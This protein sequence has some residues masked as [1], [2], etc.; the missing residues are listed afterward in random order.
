MNRNE[1][2]QKLNEMLVGKSAYSMYKLSDYVQAHLGELGIDNAQGEWR[3]GLNAYTIQII[4]K[5]WVVV[6][7]EIKRAKHKEFVWV[8][9]Q[10]VVDDYFVD[11]ETR[12]S[13]IH[14]KYKDQIERFDEWN[15][16][17]SKMSEL[18]DMLKMIRNV[19]K[20]KTKLDIL[21]LAHDLQYHYWLIDEALESEGK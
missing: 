19:Y 11:F 17:Y 3:C 13:E 14:K 9:R 20:D 8:V 16:N 18:K 4:Y 6:S 10:V 21:R 7:C 12:L 1:L 5:T 2:T 15:I